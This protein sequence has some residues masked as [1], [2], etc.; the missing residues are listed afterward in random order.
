MAIYKIKRL[1][2]LLNC[3]IEVIDNIIK[4]IDEYYY[5]KKIPKKNGNIRTITPSVKELKEIQKKIKKNIL[6]GFYY[7]EYLH[8]GI[9][10]RDNLS[11]ANTHK[12][13]KYKFNTDLKDFY[14]SISNKLVYNMFI[15]IG[16][17]PDVSHILTKLTTY[18]GCLP[19][20]AP[21][22]SHISNLVF[23]KNVD[24]EI[25][26]FCNLNNITYTRY[27]DDLSFSSQLDFKM[28]SIQILE[29]IKKYGFKINNR[30]TQY[31]IGP[32][33]ITGVKTNN[34]YL[35]TPRSQKDKLELNELSDNSRRGLENYEK[36]VKNYK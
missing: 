2:Y 10:K 24:N 35:D 30:K 23:L 12:G 5:I 21:T 9:K 15:N 11:N 3:E 17:S 4:N 19:Q 36:R 16:C 28:L 7:P 20:G 32:E 14:P 6:D 22:S 33:I 13:K 26:E 31:K 25:F 29:I 27:I 8:G 18:K 1:L 34:N